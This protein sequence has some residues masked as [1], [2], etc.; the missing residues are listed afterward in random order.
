MRTKTLLLDILSYTIGSILYGI[1]VSSFTA[2]NNISPGGMTGIATLLNFAFGTPIGVMIVLLN[3]PIVIWAIIEIGYK[4][5]VKSMIGI[6]VTSLFVDLTTVFVPVYRG[7]PIIVSLLGGVTQGLGLSLFFLR[8]ATTGGSDLI[9]NI[10]SRRHKHIS[11][12]KLIFASDGF[13]IVLSAIVFGSLESGVYACIVV[14]VATQVIDKILNGFDVGRGRIF[15]I[16]TS[17]KQEIATAIMQQVKRGVTF[18]KSRGAYTNSENEVIMC[19][20][21]GLEVSKVHEIIR[22]ID[23]NAF[24]ITGE[25]DEITGEGFKSRTNDD[26]TLRELLNLV[27]KEAK[28]NAP[29]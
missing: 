13:V 2:P 17:K 16:F 26:K 24:V 20:V 29:K 18:L 3:T 9:A 6:V 23:T 12:G 15:F 27:K 5:V 10:I 7:D 28:K 4:L 11:I 21:R 8:G 22:N 25:V 14:F 1:S 19:A